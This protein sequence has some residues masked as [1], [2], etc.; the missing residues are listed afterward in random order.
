MRF[1]L[2]QTIHDQN[3]EKLPT[4]IK[5]YLQQTTQIVLKRVCL[6]KALEIVYG[7]PI[8]PNYSLTF[9][10]FCHRSVP[11]P[12]ISKKCFSNPYF[13]LSIPQHFSSFTNFPHHCP[14]FLPIPHNSNPFQQFITIPHHYHSFPSIP[15][16]SHQIF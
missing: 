4:K 16:H 15:H 11:F 1:R 5:L 12:T 3:P 6:K 7:N 10:P 13:F 8:T 14:P 9:Q 2:H